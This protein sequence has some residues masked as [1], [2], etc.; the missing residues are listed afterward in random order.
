MCFTSPDVQ[1]WANGGGATFLF[2]VVEAQPAVAV[3]F[4]VS[5]RTAVS[6]AASLCGVGS[7]FHHCFHTVE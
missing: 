3:L 2:S 4:G 1:H 6:A 5:V 7:L